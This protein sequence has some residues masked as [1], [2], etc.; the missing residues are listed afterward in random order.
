MKTIYLKIS[1][2]LFLITGCSVNAH[3]DYA[4]PSKDFNP[5]AGTDV[6]KALLS[7]ADLNLKDEPLCDLDPEGT[8]LSDQLADSLSLNYG[9]SKQNL[10]IT[11]S[12]TISKFELTDEKVI[13]IWDCGVNITLNNKE[14]EYI[15]NSSYKFG[16]TLIE[17]EFVKGSL[18]CF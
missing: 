11:S 18:R 7:N 3:Q 9:N 10:D 12:C 5:P 4:R 14:H 2:I 17:F 6:F 8:N 13:D 16:L 1:F 15:A